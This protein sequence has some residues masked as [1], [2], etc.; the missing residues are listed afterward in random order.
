MHGPGPGALPPGTVEPE[1]IR[2][3]GETSSDLVVGVR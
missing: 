3:N 2:V 1:R